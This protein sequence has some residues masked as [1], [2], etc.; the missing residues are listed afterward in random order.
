MMNKIIITALLCAM[1]GIISAQSLGE[2]KP[3]DTAYGLNKLKKAKGADRIYIAGFD[4]NFQVYNEKQ[5][6][7]QGGRMVGGGVRGDALAEVSVGLEGLDEK[8]VQEITDQLYNDYIAK[9]KAKG[10]TIISP[11]EAAKTDTYADF[12]RMKGGG[13]SHAQIP[14]VMTS[15]PTGYEYFIKK[16]KKDGREKTGG[17]M[18][19]QAMMFPKLSSDLDGATIGTVDLTVLFISE[20]GGFKGFGAKVK[21]K[22]SLRLVGVEAVTM[23][24]NAKFKVKGANKVTM[25]T[26]TVGFYQGRAGAGAVSMYSGTLAKPLA[27]TGVID[28]EKI[29]SYARGG[30]DFYGT[31]SIYGTFYSADNKVTESAKVISIDLAKYKD[32]V[33]GAAAKFLNHHTDEFLKSL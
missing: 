16:V 2:F 33:Y 24:S 26:S 17:F 30:A 19:N 7:K 11:D 21:V 22:T 31:S 1:T 25:A 5:D 15:T 9:L 8:T 13:I 12:V 3:K 6:F 23:T 32:G 10:L 28:D 14:G 18:G 27:I 20:Q 4:V 29:T